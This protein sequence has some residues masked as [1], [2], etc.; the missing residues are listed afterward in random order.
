MI[1]QEKSEN[2]PQLFDAQ[3]LG[4]SFQELGI[5]IV[6]SENAEFVTRWFRAARADADL[7]IWL[8][9]ENRIVK[10]QLCVFGQVVE[11]NLIH[12]TRTG[13]IVETESLGGQSEE[14]VSIPLQGG[15]P[16][17]PDPSSTSEQ[18]QFDERP[19]GGTVEQAIGVLMS[20]PALK[21]SERQTLIFNLRQS[22]RL[23][24]HAREQTLRAWAPKVNDIIADVRPSFWS[25]LRSWVCGR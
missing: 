15:N 23:Q 10:H 20:V 13:L 11:W 1:T 4:A 16:S 14:R 6:R 7:T 21:D 24:P 2:R 19:L 22:P 9:G 12:G 25:R 5:D 8:D 3:A 17:R 18:I